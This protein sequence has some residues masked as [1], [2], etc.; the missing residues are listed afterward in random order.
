MSSSASFEEAPTI[1]SKNLIKLHLHLNSSELAF[2]KVEKKR[3]F[4]GLPIEGKLI[5]GSWQDQGGE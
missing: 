1:H 4:D 5:G 2:I 3:D